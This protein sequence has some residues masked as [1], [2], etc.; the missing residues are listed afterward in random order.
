MVIRFCTHYYSQLFAVL[1][2]LG[3]SRGRDFSVNIRRRVDLKPL[4]GGLLLTFPV[5]G[6]FEIRTDRLRY[7]KWIC[8]RQ[9]Q[10][11]QAISII[12]GR[13]TEQ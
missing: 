11:C 12:R 3:I 5:R 13:I 4:A 2:I 10:N 6:Q 8:L 7:G 9:R 1:P